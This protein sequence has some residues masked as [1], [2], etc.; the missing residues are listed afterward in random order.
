MPEVKRKP[1]RSPD[2]GQREHWVEG[3]GTLKVWLTAI[4]VVA[5]ANPQLQPKTLQ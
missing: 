5:E 3:R 2:R 1:R 4:G